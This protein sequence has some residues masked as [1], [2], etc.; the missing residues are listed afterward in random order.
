MIEELCFTNAYLDPGETSPAYGTRYFD[1][2]LNFIPHAIYPSKPLLGIDHV[3]WRGFDS[4]DNE[5]GE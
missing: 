2:L 4:A 5:L 3:K 1:E